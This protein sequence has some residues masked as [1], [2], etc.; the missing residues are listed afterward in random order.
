M[1]KRIKQGKGSKDNLASRPQGNK[2]KH[3]TD[4]K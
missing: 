4:E 2:V 1:N 3:S